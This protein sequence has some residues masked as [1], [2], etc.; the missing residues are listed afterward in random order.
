MTRK[1]DLYDRFIVSNQN[2]TTDHVICSKLQVLGFF[3]LI[4]QIPGLLCLNYQIPGFCF[5][6]SRFPGKVATQI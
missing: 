4:F 2:F 3:F 1:S 5:F 6:F